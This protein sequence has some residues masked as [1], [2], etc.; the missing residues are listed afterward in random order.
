[1]RKKPYERIIKEVQQMLEEKIDIRSI[2]ITMDMSEKTINKN[3]QFLL[4]DFHQGEGLFVCGK[5]RIPMQVFAS[6]EEL[7]EMGAG[8][9]N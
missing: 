6:Q 4:Q 9:D 3:E 7:E 1:M 5:K 8:Y 2:S